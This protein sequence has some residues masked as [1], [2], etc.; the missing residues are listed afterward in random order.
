[1]KSSGFLGDLGSNS[2]IGRATKDFVVSTIQ[3]ILE[4][5]LACG[6]SWIAG[7]RPFDN[8]LEGST[9]SCRPRGAGGGYQAMAQMLV[10][11]RACVID[12]QQSCWHGLL[13]HFCAII[14]VVGVLAD[15]TVTVNVAGRILAISFLKIIHY[16]PVEAEAD[17]CPAFLVARVV[18]GRGRGFRG[19]F[20]GR[21]WR[22]LRG[23]SGRDWYRIGLYA[24][25]VDELAHLL[26]ALA[27]GVVTTHVTAISVDGGDLRRGGGGA[28]GGD[29]GDEG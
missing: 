26:R 9:S 3:E 29:E 6:L 21:G 8:M 11:P 28:R 18:R 17:V 1:M 7:S 5:D 16:L 20:G 23:G 25:G 15:L 12:A 10:L 13:A 22:R 19:G 2:R 24:H 4:P 27:G 14:K